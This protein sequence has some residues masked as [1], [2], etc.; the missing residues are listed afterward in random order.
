M[1]KPLLT[2]MGKSFEQG[3]WEKFCGIVRKL[4]AGIALLT[5]VCCLGAFLLGI[6]VLSA[7]SAM[8]YRITGARW[9]F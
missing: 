6:P 5:A 2:T 8:I 7:F 4:L 3:E 1:F 9:C